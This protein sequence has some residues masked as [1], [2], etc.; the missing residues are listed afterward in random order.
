[1][2]AVVTECPTNPLVQTCDLPALSSLCRAAG[3]MLVVDPTMAGLGNASPLPH[4]DVVTLSTTKYAASCGDVMSGAVVLNPASAFYGELKA[5][6]RSAAEARRRDVEGHC[7][8]NSGS[9]GEPHTS[10]VDGDGNAATT[11]PSS[12]VVMLPP[13]HRDLL[14][15]AAEIRDCDTVVSAMN[16]NCAGVVAWLRSHMARPEGDRASNGVIRAVHW[17]Y[18]EGQSDRY[19]ALVTDTAAGADSLIDGTASPLKPGCMVTFELTSTGESNSDSSSSAAAH[20]SAQEVLSAFYDACPLVK[21]PS[22]GTTFSILCPFMYLAHYDMVSCDAGRAGLLQR[23][24]DPYLLRLSVGCEPL[25]DIIAAL[26]AGV[27]AV[28][29]LRRRRQA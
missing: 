25:P 28:L 26:Q 13:Y 6:L 23:G 21:G 22:F 8:C 17:A 19:A 16:R 12:S 4:A 9:G 14:R 24:L 1:M 29:E 3:C 5:V 27:D 7:A 15:L 11:S 2:A 18:S 10:A 20:C